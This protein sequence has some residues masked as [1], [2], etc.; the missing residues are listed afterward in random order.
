MITN[1]E[2][3]TENLTGFQLHLIKSVIEIIS[4]FHKDKPI[5]SHDLINLIN[6]KLMLDK[7]ERLTPVR[8]RKI[9]NYIRSNGL[10]PL[11]A[12]SKGYYVCYDSDEVS[13]QITSLQERA[14]AII[15][16]ANGLKIYL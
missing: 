12:T 7:D 11:I 2:E 16:S 8:F 13:L 10:L 5:K 3:I 15:N 1:F 6:Q 4:N 14:E 9:C